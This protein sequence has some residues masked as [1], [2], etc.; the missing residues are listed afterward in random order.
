[1]A[2][3]KIVITGMHA[4]SALGAGPEAMGAAMAE[5]RPA[6]ATVR[7][8]EFHELDRECTCY[9]VPDFDPVAV[10]GKK[11]LRGKDLATKLLM[12]VVEQGFRPLLDS[13]G[14]DA[15]PGLCVGTAFGSVQSIGDFLSDSIVN[16]VNAVNPVLFGNTVINSATGNTNIRFAIRDLSATISTG[17]NSGLDAI[18][19]AA[20]HIRCG[21]ARM[22]LAGGLEE[23]GYYLLVGMDRSG[24]LSSGTRCRPFAPDSDGCV[25]GEGC[26]MFVVESE[27]SARERGA[28]VIAEIA[29]SG[30]VFDPSPGSHSGAR[31]A[32]EEACEMAHV[33]TDRIGFVAAAAS[34][35]SETD[36]LEAA[37]LRDMMPE[38]PVAAYK[39]LTGECYGASPALSVA[40]ALIDMRA[41]RLSGAGGSYAARE[42]VNLVQNTTRLT[43]E[44]V[45]VNAFS[46][47]GNRG[48]LILRKPS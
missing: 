11:G 43:S 17:Y 20:D 5:N 24:V 15:L 26:A 10:L 48:C 42:G 12:A 44:Y 38:T 37:V 39:A 25:A 3:E 31:A 41:D 2:H 27:S 45:L 23:V 29:G 35:V 14:P 36:S 4:M 1:M 46:C 33:A 16:G 22:V 34:G 6:T 28:A 30:V 19:Y 18:V 13:C 7:A 21:H 47:D 40:C 8:W 9:R 32:I